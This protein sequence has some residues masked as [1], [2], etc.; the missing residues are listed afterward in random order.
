M[1]VP[2]PECRYPL[3]VH[4]GALLCSALRLVQWASS[5]DAWGVRIEWTCTRLWK[6]SSPSERSLWRRFGLR[7]SSFRKEEI[8]M[9]LFSVVSQ[10]I[11]II[12]ALV[13]I[14]ERPGDGAAKAQGGRRS[15]PREG[16]GTL[17]LPKWA[18]ELFLR[19]TFVGWLV[20]VVVWATNQFGFF[21]R[22]NGGETGSGISQSGAS[23]VSAYHRSNP[24]GVVTL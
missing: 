3:A 18:S 17:T 12:V 13:N 22:S 7:G 8:I 1:I 16:R 11:A 2:M 24:S 19:P 5:R 4:L 9:K 14:V 6:A 21:E 15:V 20:D 23:T 10:A